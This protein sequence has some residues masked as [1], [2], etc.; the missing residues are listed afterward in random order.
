MAND[1]SDLRKTNHAGF[2]VNETGIIINDDELAW[3]RYKS[4][5][6]K[7]KLILDLKKQIDYLNKKM[8]ELE[9]RIDETTSRY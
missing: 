5:R 2:F 9:R 7:T 6:E 8:I 1:G 3:M 4:E